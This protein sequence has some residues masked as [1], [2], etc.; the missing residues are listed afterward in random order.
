MQPCDNKLYLLEYAL[1]TN[2]KSVLEKVKCFADKY[3][4]PHYWDI[5]QI[6]L[7]YPIWDTERKK[8]NIKS[9][10]AYQGQKDPHKPLDYVPIKI[11]AGWNIALNSFFEN[12]T[13]K[14]PSKQQ[15]LAEFYWDRDVL[16]FIL[17]LPYYTIFLEL[18]EYTCNDRETSL[19][20]IECYFDIEDKKKLES[21][22]CFS[23]KEAQEQ[24]NELLWKYK[25]GIPDTSQK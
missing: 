17:E 15:T 21:I 6:K 22:F 19:L 7:I 1:C 13:F 16:A 3:S 25:N 20:H 18:Q 2:I 12:Y 9:M 8:R 10:M 24:L 4:S 5:N 11:P 14:V 23:V